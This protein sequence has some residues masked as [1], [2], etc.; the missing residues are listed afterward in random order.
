MRADSE[1][2]S[3]R[4]HNGFRKRRVG[5]YR[6]IKVVR[7]GSHLYGERRFRN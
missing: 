2:R 3:R 7:R 1:R 5:M 4:F 6:Q